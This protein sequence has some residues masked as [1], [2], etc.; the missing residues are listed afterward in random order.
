MKPKKD[1][2]KIK[3]IKIVDSK[4]VKP[5]T[6]EDKLY[7]YMPKSNYIIEPMDHDNY[8]TIDLTDVDSYIKGI[9]LLRKILF[10]V[11]QEELMKRKNT[12]MDENS[13]N[14]VYREANKLIPFK[15]DSIKKGSVEFFMRCSD[16]YIVGFRVGDSNIE[17]FDYKKLRYPSSNDHSKYKF[18]EIKADINSLHVMGY[19]IA[20]ATRSD[21]VKK[22]IEEI[23]TADS[24]NYTLDILFELEIDNKI[25][26]EINNKIKTTV[27]DLAHDWVHCKIS[28]PKVKKANS[29]STQEVISGYYE[30]DCLTLRYTLKDKLKSKE[31]SL[32]LSYPNDGPDD[33]DK[34]GE[35]IHIASS[36]EKD[37]VNGEDNTIPY[38]LAWLNYIPKLLRHQIL[39]S[40][41]IKSLIEFLKSFS[42]TYKIKSFLEDFYY[43]SYYVEQDKHP[44]NNMEDDNL[45]KAQVNYK[46]SLS[47][48]IDQSMN[49]QMKNF[50]EG[51]LLLSGSLFSA[52]SIYP[53]NSYVKMSDFKLL[54]DAMQDCQSLLS[55]F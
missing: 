2:V 16:L 30:R 20:E 9:S 22:H 15:V 14:L 21:D 49:L 3:S 1:R 33:N 54:G 38:Y 25:N 12:K 4:D 52:S 23:I 19:V 18:N 28:Q 36:S 8:I 46:D 42:A 55:T 13:V 39:D 34:G 29:N 45:E 26:N 48:M 17:I 41:P 27:Y 31:H 44:N 24:P 43:K 51:A 7:I 10:E 32:Q 6:V 50:Q 11:E 35:A 40:M 5:A 53:S 37:K 47:S